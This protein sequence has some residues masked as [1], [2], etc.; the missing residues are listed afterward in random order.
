MQSKFELA[1]QL[2]ADGD[3]AEADQ[4]HSDDC[5][6]LTDSAGVA[7]SVSQREFEL[8]P[9]AGTAYCRTQLA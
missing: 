5:M 8:A 3:D 4:L 2:L 7:A 9:R 6:W 1:M